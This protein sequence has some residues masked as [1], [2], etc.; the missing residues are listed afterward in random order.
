MIQLIKSAGLS[1]WCTRM[2]H[3][4][5]LMRKSQREG[6]QECNIAW[7]GGVLS[8]SVRVSPAK[9]YTHLRSTKS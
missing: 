1:R 3:M 8:R 9:H 4:D 5:S 6:M 7:R 2:W